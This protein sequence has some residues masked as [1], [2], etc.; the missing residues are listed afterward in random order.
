MDLIE[1][2]NK[3]GERI[4][5]WYPAV[6]TGGCCVYAAAVGKELE[7]RGIET[8]IIVAAWG[9]RSNLDKVRPKLNNAN[10]KEE[11]NGKD[12]WFNHV[13]VE[14]KHKGKTFHYDTDGVNAKRRTLKSWNIYPGRLSV[15][16]ATALA[17]EPEGWN[18]YF[19]RKKI[20]SMKRHIR[21]FLAANLPQ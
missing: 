6:N 11:W 13:G 3:L 14:F 1:T 8:R 16:E 17:D 15:D 19:N 5:R 2:L 20:P 21:S 4:N 12:V 10:R 9:A 7:A 18:D